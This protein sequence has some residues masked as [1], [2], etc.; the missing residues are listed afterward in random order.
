MPH[1]KL[2]TIYL[3]PPFAG[4]DLVMMKRSQTFSPSAPVDGWFTTSAI[5]WRTTLHIKLENYTSPKKIFNQP[6]VLKRGIVIVLAGHHPSTEADGENVRDRVII[7]K[8]VPAKVGTKL[9]KIG[10]YVTVFFCQIHLYKVW[11]CYCTRSYFQFSQ[12]T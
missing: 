3:V 9:A 8:S 7:S 12:I 11:R 4:T 10:V 5:T 1:F 6:Q 2:E